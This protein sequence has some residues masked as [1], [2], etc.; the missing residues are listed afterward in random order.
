M[1]VNYLIH[2]RKLL[3]CLV[4]FKILFSMCLVIVAYAKIALSKKNT[5]AVTEVVPIEVSFLV[6][7]SKQK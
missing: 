4:S 6:V 1:S 2:I 7:G 5:I 3:N